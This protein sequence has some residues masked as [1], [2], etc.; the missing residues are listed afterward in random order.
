[1]KKIDLRI[2]CLSMRWTRI[3][4][5]SLLI[6]LL[7]LYGQ[8]QVTPKTVPDGTEGDVLTV[9]EKDTLATKKKAKN[10]G[11]N[12]FDLGFTTLKLGVGFLYEYNGF[13]QDEAGKQQ[14][15]SIGSE[16]KNAFGSRDFR[17]LFSGKLNTR[18]TITWKFAM[19]YDGVTE[20][21]VVRESGLIFGLPELSSHV[22]IGRT[23]EGFSQ[24]KVMNGYSGWTLER[25]TALDIIP[26]L[27]DGIKWF[28]FLPK[29]R[30]FWNAGAYVD[31]LSKGQGFSTFESQYSG[32]VGWLPVYKPE[33]NTLLHVGVNLRYAKPLDDKLKVRSRP[34]ANLAP[35]FIDAGTLPTGQVTNFG[36]EIYYSRGPL[37][38]GSEFYTHNINSPDAGNPSF[39]GG[40]VVATYIF[41]GES[42]PYTTTGGNIYG[43]VPV[44]KSL[45][46]G[47]LGC[48]EA[49]LRFSVFDLNDG[50]VEGGKMWR[51]TPAVN[52]YMTRNISLR[53]TYGYAVLD[54][55]GLQGGTQIFHTRLQVA[56]L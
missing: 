29:Q 40:D 20:E 28:G 23:K 8:G 25:Q 13:V 43:F 36:G 35:F 41:T 38:L 31:W 46:K 26:I 39:V 37:M 9:P 7:P 27:A 48:W 21:W 18:R 14:T 47:G 1:M 6:A 12:E 49:L 2:S 34:E 45:F 24:N 30:I 19:M 55:F 53:F 32:R 33:S 10:L 50:N 3:L 22:F 56:I 44:K 15:D 51:I 42:R 17:F 11:W 5:T 54:R 4:K 52:W 16:L